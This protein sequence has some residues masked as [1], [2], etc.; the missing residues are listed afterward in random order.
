MILKLFNY[1]FHNNLDGAPFVKE[2]KLPHIKFH[3]NIYKKRDLPTLFMIGFVEFGCES[4][5]PLYVLPNI[6]RDNPHFKVIFVGWSGREYLY[7]HIVDEYW[8]LD[9]CFMYL[10]NTARA[11][12]HESFNLK[13]VEVY[14]SRIGTVIKSD[15]VGN[16]LIEYM[17]LDCFYKS[18][19]TKHI[20]GCPACGLTKIRQ[21]L[22]SNPVDLRNKLYP[23]PELKEE[24]IEN[25]KAIMPKKAV[26][27]F[28]RKRDSYGRNLDK[29]FYLRLIDL[30]KEMGYNPVW[31]GEKNSSLE[32][33]DSEILDF[34]SCIESKDLEKVISLVSLCEF[35]I[36]FWTASTR[37]SLISNTK[38][39]LVECPD[40]IYGNGQEGIRLNI[41]NRYETPY[42]LFL[43]NYNKFI[44]NLNVTFTL[45][46][47]SLI[48]FVNQNNYEDTTDMTDIK[49]LEGLKNKHGFR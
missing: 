6:V 30:L 19:S 32:C 41:F 43:C 11:M 14:L 28:A 18:G 36:Q 40:Q 31:I 12:S 38:F 26:A 35:S 22:L 2:K 39:F 46:K 17:C 1:K 33:P 45:L 44:E 10:R 23:L 15:V 9:S 21:S 8:E 49:Y 20:K 24:K 4:F 34:T 29:N 13:Q 47:K 48:E 5:F 37:I 25:I 42:K 16:N 7:K 3:K 27:V